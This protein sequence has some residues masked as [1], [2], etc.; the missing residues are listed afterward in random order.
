MTT[1]MQRR[2]CC[3]LPGSAVPCSGSAARTAERTQTCSSGTKVTMEIRQHLEFFLILI[4][5]KLK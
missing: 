1:V 3:H 5:L 4:I 2:W